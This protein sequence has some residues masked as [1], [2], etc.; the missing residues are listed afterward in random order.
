MVA[1][2]FVVGGDVK[3]LH[4]MSASVDMEVRSNFWVVLIFI[5]LDNECLIFSVFGGYAGC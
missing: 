4:E 2:S 5:I 3:L 1:A